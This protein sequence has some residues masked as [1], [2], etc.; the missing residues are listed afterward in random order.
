MGM[1]KVKLFVVL[2]IETLQWVIGLAEPAARMPN[3]RWKRPFDVVLH[4]VV[5]KLHAADV[6]WSI[7][8]DALREDVFHFSGR[9]AG[10]IQKTFEAKNRLD[11]PCL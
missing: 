4:D 10:Q 5:H 6:M 1:D 11:W 7:S 3:C 9:E 2:P 8:H